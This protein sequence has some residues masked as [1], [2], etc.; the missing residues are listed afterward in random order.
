[1][2]RVSQYCVYCLSCYAIIHLV[3]VYSISIGQVGVNRN[4][5]E[6]LENHVV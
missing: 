5:L 3:L 4:R 1:M 2:K 6:T